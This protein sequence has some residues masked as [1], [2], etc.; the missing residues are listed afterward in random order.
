MPL[1]FFILIVVAIVFA[2]GGLG[3]LVNYYMALS[4]DP[5][6]ARLSHSLVIGL[7]AAFLVPLFLQ[8]ISSDLLNDAK[9]S[10]SYIEFFI[11]AGF[12]LVAAI[13]S[14]AFVQSLTSRVLSQVQEA[15]VHA[16]QALS[17]AEI[18]ETQ[19]KEAQEGSERAHGA[20]A[21]AEMVA[22]TVVPQNAMD[23]IAGRP[24]PTNL[25]SFDPSNSSPLE[26]LKTL[27]IEYDK[28]RKDYRSGSR[29]TRL[30][31]QI[32]RQMIDLSPK[33]LGE[34]SVSERLSEPPRD[35][36]RGRRLAAYAYL[37]YFPDLQQLDELVR[38]VTSVEDK[39]FG[40][41]WGL[42]AISRVTDDLRKN[43]VSSDVYD[44]L[45]QFRNNTPRNRD[46]HH[47]VSRILDQLDAKY[48]DD[49]E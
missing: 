10:D 32:V 21:A 38:S 14:R 27:E 5:T 13:S 23:N 4:S 28:V 25:E 17:K 33:L 2:A 42:Q 12:C 31:T 11:F 18:A 22:L 9:A 35:G 44:S 46:R 15:R 47:V 19:A 29:R 37:N 49:S 30:M 20:A 48:D 6:N 16:E 1:L 3:G 40:H 43:D 34:L 39:P 45:T 8:M 24:Q 36:R 7:A 41:Y 26:I